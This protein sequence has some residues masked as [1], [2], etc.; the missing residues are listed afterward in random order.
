[1]KKSFLKVF[2]ALT[3]I[4]AGSFA[5]LSF[6]SS[7]AQNSSKFNDIAFSGTKGASKSVTPMM[8]G[9]G[10]YIITV[11]NCGF[12]LGQQSF[13]SFTGVYGAPYDCEGFGCYGTITHRHCV[14]AP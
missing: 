12:D 10:C 5:V 13:C 2:T 3:V 11:L 14:L 4:L 7:H 8:N 6:Q 1:M 9:Q